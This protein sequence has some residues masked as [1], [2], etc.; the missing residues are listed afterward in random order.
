MFRLHAGLLTYWIREAGMSS[1]W[2]TRLGRFWRAVPFLNQSRD[3]AFGVEF[4]ILFGRMRANPN[5][6]I[7]DMFTTD[8]QDQ[9]LLLASRE[10]W[11]VESIEKV[12]KGWFK[13]HMIPPE[14]E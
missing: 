7:E 6:P 8:N 1:T 14:S 13:I 12:S 11:H 9:I 10:K 4:G 2:P 5:E 3:F